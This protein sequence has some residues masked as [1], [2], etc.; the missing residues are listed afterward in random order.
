MVTPTRRA[1]PPSTCG[2]GPEPH[3]GPGLY[4]PCVVDAACRHLSFPTETASNPHHPTPR[5]PPDRSTIIQFPLFGERPRADSRATKTMSDAAVQ[6]SRAACTKSLSDTPV[7]SNSATANE[8]RPL[9]RH[10]VP[11]RRGGWITG[12]GNRMSRPRFAKVKLT[13]FGSEF[14][15]VAYS[16]MPEECLWSSAVRIRCSVS[17]RASGH[18][19]QKIYVQQSSDLCSAPTCEMLSYQAHQYDPPRGRR[20]CGQDITHSDLSLYLTTVNNKQQ[21]QRPRD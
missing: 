16:C 5:L 11:P 20:E 12:H 14:R 15:R 2:S 10:L 21:N 19:T 1:R 4:V 13:Y 17:N 3:P 18:T 6:L 7:Y 8:A 9:P